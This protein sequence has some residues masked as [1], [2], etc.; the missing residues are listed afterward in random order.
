MD[1]RSRRGMSQ[2]GL[3]LLEVVV[4][5]ALL[6]LLA[7]ATTPLLREAA[8]LGEAHEPLPDTA[9]LGLAVDQFLADPAAHGFEH[10]IPERGNF[11]A[12]DLGLRGAVHFQRLAA[13]GPEADGSWMVFRGGGAKVFR[14]EA[15]PEVPVVE[16]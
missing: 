2:R 3:T 4:A 7:A 5:V 11:V 9:A 6:V 8:R 13:P 1:P 10:E 12:T 15:K 16:R 14:W